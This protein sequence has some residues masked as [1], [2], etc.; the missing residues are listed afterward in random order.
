MWRGPCGAG[1]GRGLGGGAIKASIA[2]PV[3]S[4]YTAM[5]TDP[6]EA[7]RAK[8]ILMVIQPRNFIKW[9]PALSVRLASALYCLC[10]ADLG[11]GT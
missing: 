3:W 11:G 5:A 7:I 6:L 1:E 9:S 2:P 4:N 8:S 10:E